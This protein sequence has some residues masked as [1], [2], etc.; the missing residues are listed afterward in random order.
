MHCG[1]WRSIVDYV[2]TAHLPDGRQRWILPEGET[3]IGRSRPNPVLL[4][5]ESVSKVHALIR[6]TGD[7]I[8]ILDLGSKNGTR[9]NQRNV[10]SAQ[11][12]EPGDLITVGNVALQVQAAGLGARLE[13][14]PDF[15]LPE[16]QSLPPAPRGDGALATL[17]DLGEFLVRRHDRHEICEKALDKAWDLVGYDLASILLLGDSGLTV[18]SRRH[19]GDSRLQPAFSH[20]LLERAIHEKCPLLITDRVDP[21]VSMVQQ[22]IRSAIVLPLLDDIHMLGVLYLDSRW[23][24]HSYTEQDLRRVEL[25]AAAVALKLANSDLVEE[26]EQAAQVQRSLLPTSLWTPPGYEMFARLD[27]C[28]TVAGDL[29]DCIPM[30]G[31]RLAIVI[32]DVCGKGTGAALLMASVLATLRALGP[33]VDDALEIVGRLGEHLGEGDRSF[34]TLFLSILDPQRHT[35]SYV[36]AGHGSTVL[37]DMDG[38][39]RDLET[40]GP[41]V[42]MQLGV[43]YASHTI[44]LAPGA[45]L[46]TWSDGFHEAHRSDVESIEFFGE[47]RLLETFVDLRHAA[48]TDLGKGVFDRV[49]AFQGGTRALD[50]RTLVLLRRTP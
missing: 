7:L 33:R 46:C 40:T 48:L 17:L 10:S 35:L 42:G 13:S 11:R 37:F 15:D 21:T 25:L 38:S 8:E 23:P 30:R 4:P 43:P 31:G 5:H 19:K 26:L 32:G 16:V 34:V 2:L 49:D 45:L 39:R 9:V 50:D 1:R 12:V 41:P 14:T 28:T 47:E 3:R 44:D 27:P 36:N 20:S 22:R 24:G 6:R 18:E 29:Y